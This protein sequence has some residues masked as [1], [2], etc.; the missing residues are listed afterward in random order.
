M[1]KLLMAG[2]II[3]I[4]GCATPQLHKAGATHADAT[5][6]NTECELMGAQYASGMGFNGNLLIVADYKA[7]CLRGRGWN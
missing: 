5:K 6:D 7:Q 1:K 4:S 2:L 3:L